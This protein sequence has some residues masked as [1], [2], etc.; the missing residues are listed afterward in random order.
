MCGLRISRNVD[1]FSR[2]VE[3]KFGGQNMANS[4]RK[5]IMVRSIAP[6]GTHGQSLRADDSFQ[7]RPGS[8][9]QF[10]QNGWA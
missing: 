8:P 3:Y 2:V 5:P 4:E 9:L 7:L 1:E 10:R 6:I